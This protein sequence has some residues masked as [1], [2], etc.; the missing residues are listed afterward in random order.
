M[1]DFNKDKVCEEIKRAI[2]ENEP[3][4][5]IKTVAVKKDDE[6]GESNALKV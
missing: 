6:D 5:E 2:E 3:R 4:A 1:N